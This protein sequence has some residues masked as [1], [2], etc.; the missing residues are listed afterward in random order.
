V[1][2]N[3]QYIDATLSG[4]V[5]FG[6]ACLS[7]SLP[8][9]STTGPGSADGFSE[10][11]GDDWS[12]GLNA[13]LLYE[14]DEHTR[15]GIAYRSRIS[16]IL[17]GNIRYT[18]PSNISAGDTAI[19][20]S[21]FPDSD[22]SASVNLPETVSVSVSRDLGSR[23]EVLGD[24]T[25]TR[26]NRFQELRVI[27]TSG[28]QSGQTATVT[29]ESWSNSI[30]VSLGANYRY[31]DKWLLRTGIA[32]DEE[33]IPDAAHRTPR[34]PGNDRRWL[35]LGAR[36]SPSGGFAFDIGYAHLFVSDAN[37]NHTDALGNTLIGKYEN[38]VDILSAQVVW[39]F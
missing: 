16:H 27:R 36:Y 22:V 20:A 23:W 32:F 24:F 29:P 18:A 17:K 26:W 30:R 1:G 39:K 33:P 14:P 7:P 15:I 37:S 13:G 28:A 34:I 10:M 31:N 11:S 4:A 25:W 3:L 6:T 5:D 8:C 19:F 21:V 35:A 12:W 2:L 38:A 9:G